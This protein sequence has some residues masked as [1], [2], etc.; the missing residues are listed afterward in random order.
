[1]AR[2]IFVNVPVKDLKKAVA[3]F[4]ELGFTFDARFTDDNATCMIVG[5]TIFVMLLVEKFFKG[6]IPDREICD[7][8]S[9]T[10]A[11]LGI[12]ASSKDEVDRMVEQAVAAGGKEFREASDHGWMYARA[13]SDLDGHIWEV[14]HMDE[15][16]M[17][18]EMRDR[19]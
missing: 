16:R 6:F 1:M 13:F 8:S 11:L 12:T 19:G 2:Q 4:T 3:F 18:A 15:S 10:E 7:T 5:D 17:P 14:F 9:S